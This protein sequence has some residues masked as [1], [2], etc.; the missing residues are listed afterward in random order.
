MSAA[1]WAVTST[2]EELPKV[3]RYYNNSGSV[4]FEDIL[5]SFVKEEVECFVRPSYH[6]QQVNVATS[7]EE[8]V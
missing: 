7:N 1:Q 3:E 8:V 6:D 4:S 2:K 5:R